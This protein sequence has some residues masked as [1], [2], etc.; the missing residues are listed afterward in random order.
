MQA[1]AQDQ[2]TIWAEHNLQNELN[3]L[4]PREEALWRDKAKAKWNQEDDANNR[5]YHLTTLVHRRY[6]SI[7]CIISSNNE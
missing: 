3:E 6:N 4:L 2:N 1:Q 7:T 5:Y